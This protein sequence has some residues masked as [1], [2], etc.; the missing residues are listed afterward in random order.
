MTA[1]VNAVLNSTV[2]LLC[3]ELRDFTAE[4]LN[5]MNLNDE[6]CRQIVVLELDDIKAKLDGLSRKDLLACLSFLKEGVTR[7]YISLDIS[8][9]SSAHPNTSKPHKTDKSKFRDATATRTE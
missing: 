5:E 2:G 9:E 1:I 4:T 6:K 7:L 3:N 8:G